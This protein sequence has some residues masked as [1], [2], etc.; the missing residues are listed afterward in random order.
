M[1]NRPYHPR[2][3]LVNGFKLKDH[4]SYVTWQSMIARC[5][6]PKAT[7]YAAR[8][9]T[10]CDRWLSFKNFV[11]DMG[12]R[13]EGLTLDRIDVN[14]NYE[15]GNCRWASRTEQCV[16][17]RK[18]SSNTSG[19]TGVIKSKSQWVARFDY[20]GVRYNIG[21]FKT[22][23]EA[24]EA[25]QRFL[26]LF[27]EDRDVAIASL[28]KDKPRSQSKTGVRGVNPHVDGG[29]IVRINVDKKRVYLGCYKTM[30]EAINAKQRF[31]AER[32]G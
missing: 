11:E 1:P 27:V 31:I 22:K 28:P 3:E 15:P 20:E 13:P 18:F 19:Y 17:R 2:G 23:I 25:R 30:E 21:W 4:P 16:N 14:G 32:T 12:E 24:N 8:G 29:Y 6:T 9:I 5:S 7:I 26:K 10:V